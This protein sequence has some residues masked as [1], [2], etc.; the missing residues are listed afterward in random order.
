MLPL[1]QALGGE[2][3]WVMMRTPD[4]ESKLAGE[5]VTWGYTPTTRNLPNLFRNRLLAGKVLRD[6]RPDLVVSTGAALAV[7]FFALA[8]RYRARTIYV[9]VIDRISTRTL[10]GRLVYPFTDAFLVQWPDQVRLY[11]ESQVIGPVI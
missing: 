10:T 8:R 11:P 3:R 4:A 9:E 6:F 7:P 5:H 2:Q 1:A